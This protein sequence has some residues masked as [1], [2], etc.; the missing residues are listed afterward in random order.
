MK[1]SREQAAENR[2]RILNVAAMQFREHGFDGIGV[3]D[4]MKKAGLTHG[5]FY[6]NF[7]SKED[8][9]AQACERALSR[10]LAYWDGHI[11]K[12]PEDAL[13]I[14]TGDY[15]SAAHRDAPGKGC[16]FTALGPEMARQ[17]PAVRA[18]ATAGV[19]GLIGRLAKLVQG[20]SKAVKQERATAMFATMVGA[21]VLARAVDDPELSEEILQAARDAIAR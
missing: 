4:L 2:E 19:R 8:L 15:L 1:V 7:A 11:E 10:S 20:K 9:M 16:T 6:G 14:I 18:S 13:A 21:V 5:G 17:N 3:A 12:S